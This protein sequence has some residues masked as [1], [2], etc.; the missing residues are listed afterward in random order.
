MKQLEG[1]APAREIPR[2]K[3]DDVSNND[4]VDF[5]PPQSVEE[6]IK[7]I[8]VEQELIQVNYHH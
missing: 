5:F 1:N 4:E 6:F 3:E 8:P 7:T 2:S